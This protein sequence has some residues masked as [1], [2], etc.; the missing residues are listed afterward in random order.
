MV[1]I[2]LFAAAW[3]SGRSALPRTDTTSIRVEQ[4]DTLWSLAER[5][6]VDGM[7]TAQTVELLA[8]LNQIDDATIRVGDVLDV[9]AALSFDAGAAL[10]MR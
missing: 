7:T 8:Q 2:L 10:A 3:F 5:H 4:G 9:P 6:Q 1:V